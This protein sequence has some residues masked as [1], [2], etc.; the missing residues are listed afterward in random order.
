MGFTPGKN[1]FQ[2]V[3]LLLRRSFVLVTVLICKLLWVWIRFR[4]IF[5]LPNLDNYGYDIYTSSFPV[6]VLLFIFAKNGGE[7]EED[8]PTVPLPPRSAGTDNKA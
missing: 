5:L 6:S 4:V 7:G 3:L 1:A 2:F 8:V